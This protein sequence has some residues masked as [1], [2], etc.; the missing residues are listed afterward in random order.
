LQHALRAIL[1]QGNMEQDSQ[2]EP[3]LR[4]GDLGVGV[5]VLGAL[6]EQMKDRP[7]PVDL[8]ALWNR[9]GVE[10]DARGVHF[11]DAAPQAAVRVAMTRS[12]PP[13]G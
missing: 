2:I 11:D 5:P 6:Y 1:A 8:D 13:P 10:R 3:L 7:V 9:L 4:I 12:V